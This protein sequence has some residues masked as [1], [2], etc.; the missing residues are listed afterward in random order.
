MP[1]SPALET[2]LLRRLTIGRLMRDAREAAGRDP[3]ACA[4]AIG[5]SPQ[6]LLAY[7]A[8]QREPTFV[9]LEAL[10]YYLG[11]PI[12]ALLYEEPA[13]RINAGANDLP[14]LMQLRARVVGARLKQARLQ[15]GESLKATA[16]ALGIA[17]GRLN[18]Y[19][20]GR[21]PIPITLLE[22]ALVHFGMTLDQILDL[23]IGPIGEAQQRL[24][25]HARFDGLP[26]DVRAFV[27]SPAALPY[28]QFAM[29]LSKLSLED[30]AGMAK[31]LQQ[32]SNPV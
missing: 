14:T 4:R 21:L 19:E 26:E 20:L 2:A 12:Q 8:G 13:K 22:K 17:S 6:R 23:G 28:L 10:A 31:A 29:H 15:R 25:Q 5:I 16:Q 24:A 18:S 32:L 9:E 3:K 27:T 30:L 1:D 7:E 11:L